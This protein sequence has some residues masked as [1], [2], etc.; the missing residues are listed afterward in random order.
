MKSKS[1]VKPNSNSAPPLCVSAPLRETLEDNDRKK[2]HNHSISAPPLCVSAPLR[3]TPEDI[4]QKKKPYHSIDNLLPESMSF[5][6]PESNYNTYSAESHNA[7]SGE[8]VNIFFKVHL[9]LGPGLL[10]SVYEKV[11]CFELEKLNIPFKYQCG[12]PVIYEGQK[13]ELGFRAD[14]IV[15][16]RIIVEIK[17]IEAI[18]PVHHKQLLTYLKLAN[19]RLG[20]L[21]NFNT[22]LIKDGITRIVN[23][24]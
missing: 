21:V 7:L 16:D 2:K 6:E 14:I 9:N 20:L 12:I 5:S 23:K 15:D 4:Y 24:L 11:I 13:M 10:E 1:T 18:A 17:S 19:K 3:E 8:L 22:A